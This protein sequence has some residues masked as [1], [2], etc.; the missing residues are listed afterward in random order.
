MDNREKFKELRALTELN[1]AEF[2][3]LIGFSLDT[4]KSWECGR[5]RIKERIIKF[6]L[7]VV[8]DYIEDSE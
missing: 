7:Y 4:V 8:T 5:L 3:K 1:Q 2:G 6:V